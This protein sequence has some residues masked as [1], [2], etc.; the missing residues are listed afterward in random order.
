MLKV[1]QARVAGPM[2]VND[3]TY[4]P[5]VGLW[6]GTRL[7]PPAQVAWMD[8]DMEAVPT[9]PDKSGEVVGTNSDAP[10]QGR[11]AASPRSRRRPV[12]GGGA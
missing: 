5:G 3:C 4:E 11:P 1:K 12:G 2:T 6:V 10:T 8:V 7:Y 9:P